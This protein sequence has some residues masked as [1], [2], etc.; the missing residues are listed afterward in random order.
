MLEPFIEPFWV[1]DEA[2][3]RQLAE[4]PIMEKDRKICLT[5]CPEYANVIAKMH[6]PCVYIE[7]ENSDTGVYGVDLIFAA[8]DEKEAPD[9]ELLQKIW[10][11]HY[12][13]PWQIVETERL[14]IRESVIADLPEFVK[15]YEEERGNPDVIPMKEPPKEDLEA[16]IGW[17]YPLWGYGL[18]SVVEKTSG[19]VIGRVGFQESFNMETEETEEM[20]TELAYLVAGAYRGRGI[21]EEAVEAVLR[22]GKEELGLTEIRLCTSN[23]NIPSQKLAEK[24]GFQRICKRKT[25]NE[26]RRIL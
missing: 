20:R 17:R 8:E 18:W 6:C 12:H 10:Q 25:Q 9:Q 24:M 22:Y 3:L 2:A 14:L 1:K 15:M 13:I 26:W 23:N 5:N 7:S 19:L 16:Y 21:A 11:R 4:R